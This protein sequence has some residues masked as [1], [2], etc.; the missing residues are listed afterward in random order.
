MNTWRTEWQVQQ[1]AMTA[2]VLA[3]VDD[4]A[5][6]DAV[7]AAIVTALALPVN[8]STDATC[9]AYLQHRQEIRYL[10]QCFDSSGETPAQRAARLAALAERVERERAH[11]AQPR[12]FF[13]AAVN[14]ARDLDHWTVTDF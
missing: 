8:S 2:H 14:T 4:R 6:C 13:Q 7:L 11:A 1:A 5:R 9:A 10:Q 12:Q 3:D